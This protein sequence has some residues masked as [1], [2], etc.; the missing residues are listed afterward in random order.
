MASAFPTTSSEAD[1]I[2]VCFAGLRATGRRALIPYLTAGYPA[3]AH[4]APLL[5]ALAGSGADIIE[6][7][8]P[9]SDP[10]ADGPTIQRASFAALEAGATLHWTLDVLRSFRSE[11]DVPVVLFSYINPILGYGV[12]RFIDAAAAAGAAGVLVTDLPA[13]SEPELEQRFQDSPLAFI[14]LVAPTTRPDRLLAIAREAQGFLYYVGRM[15]V[16]GARTAL[17]QET[18]QEVAALR[19]AVPLPVAVGF[20]ISTPDQAASVAR[21]ADGVIV[22]SALIDALD[23]G[24]SDSATGLLAAM[25]A[26]MDAGQH[27]T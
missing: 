12:D 13:G 10:V 16:T 11:S 27:T 4:T 25:R 23:E 21:V 3:R 15:G 18:L 26:A 7:G 9:F 14:R 8:V 24:G 5:A 19:A 6:L 17:R 20:G 1:P 2:A 22:G